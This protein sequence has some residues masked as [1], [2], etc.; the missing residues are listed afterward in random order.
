M[1]QIITIGREFGSGG[2][3]LG[4]RLAEMLGYAYYDKEIIEE[5]A[6]RTQLA[7][8]YVHQIVEQQSGVFFPITIGRTLHHVQPVGSDYMLRQY[9][10]VY[11]EQANVLREMAE[12]SNCIIVGRCADYILKDHKPLRLFVYADM[13]SKIERCRKKAEDHEGLSDRD[14]RRKIRRVD[15][16]RAKY[17]QY[18]TGHTWGSRANYD[19][20]VNTSAVSVK[21]VAE[22]LSNMLK[23][24]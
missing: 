18:Y 1:N 17:Y 9:T 4:K 5:I 19:L 3:E 22:A 8:S 13:D 11:S 12:K 15:K 21:E 10:A 16:S 6:K 20:C 2:R 14:L 7:E 23:Q 24:R